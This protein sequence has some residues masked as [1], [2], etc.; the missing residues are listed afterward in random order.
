[1]SI[2]T[3]DLPQISIDISI[4]SSQHYSY[5][6]HLWTDNRFIKDIKQNKRGK[7]ASTK[8]GTNSQPFDLITLLSFLHTIYMV[9]L[10]W[11]CL[12]HGKHHSSHRYIHKTLKLIQA[13]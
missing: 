2:Y 4:I 12:Q 5:Q 1:M 10:P 11:T 9:H 6:H 8:D 7:L 3:S 13:R